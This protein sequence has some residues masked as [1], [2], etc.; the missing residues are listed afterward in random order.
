MTKTKRNLLFIILG[1]ILA[2]GVTVGICLLV[3][4]QNASA[5]EKVKLYYP[6]LLKEGRYYQNGD[7]NSEFYFEVKDGKLSLHGD[8]DK[9]VQIVYGYWMEL[10]GDDESRSEEYREKTLKEAEKVVDY[11]MKEQDYLVFKTRPMIAEDTEYLLINSY[12]KETYKEDSAV[13][14]TGYFFNGV[15]TIEYWCDS[16]FILVK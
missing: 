13:S 2:I 4:G 3:N 9:L 10:N 11:D 7:A 16:P 15:D 6:E 5:E 12:D 14:G 1:I 8:R